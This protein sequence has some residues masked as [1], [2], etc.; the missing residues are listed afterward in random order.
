MEEALNFIASF[1]EI[2]RI[3]AISDVVKM[4]NGDHSKQPNPFVDS[5]GQIKSSLSNVDVINWGINPERLKWID[6][7]MSNAITRFGKMSDELCSWINVNVVEEDEGARIT[8]ML[9][10]YYTKLQK[11]L[12]HQNLL[13]KITTYNNKLK[14]SEIKDKNLLT[15]G[16]DAVNDSMQI[17]EMM[18]T[19][20][21]LHIEAVKKCNE[22]R[23]EALLGSEPARRGMPVDHQLR[24]NEEE[25]D[26]EAFFKD[27]IEKKHILTFN[28]ENRPKEIM[29]ILNAVF[30]KIKIPKR[31][32]I[33]GDL[34]GFEFVKRQRFYI[35]EM[36]QFTEDG[37][38]FARKFGPLI[39]NHVIFIDKYNSAAD[40]PAITDIFQQVFIIGGKSY[41]PTT[42]SEYL[43]NHSHI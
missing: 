8:N 2:K 17:I 12:T 40:R 33:D 14:A 31:K 29:K 26:F 43:R 9:E 35:P 5:A 13:S 25:K 7:V 21:E 41:E 4:C 39:E 23:K 28:G 42:L 24:W 30:E 1:G 6:F 32:R 15:L 19:E 3:I 36:L 16:S 34:V 27:L 11:N 10:E 18:F 37:K 20:F 22:E 38:A